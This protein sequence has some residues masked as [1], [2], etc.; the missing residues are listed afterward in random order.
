MSKRRFILGLALAWPSLAMFST[1]SAQPRTDRIPEQP[2]IVAR[3]AQIDWTSARRA[4]QQPVRTE[5]SKRFIEANRKAIDQV[6]LPVLL[7]SDPD[8]HEG[9]RF[10]PNRELYVLSSKSTNLAFTLSGSA[11]AFHLPE[12]MAKTLSP[13]G[14]LKSRIPADGILIEQTESGIDASFTR[15]G[16]PYSISVECAGGAKDP[17][18]ADGA[19]IRGLIAR[20]AV[21]VPAQKR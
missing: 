2:R 12:G 11:R 7:P 4:E 19:Y 21:A 5:V 14:G 10:F 6:Q 13:Q 9:L 17:R 3:P 16:V 8:L 1:M 20:M 18:C 15:Y